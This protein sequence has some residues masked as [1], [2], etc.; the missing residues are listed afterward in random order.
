VVVAGAPEAKAQAVLAA[1]GKLV[2]AVRAALARAGKGED[3]AHLQMLW[4][5]S[6]R[7]PHHRNHDDA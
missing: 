6:L 5:R 7:R 2:E 4:I 1:E 3:A